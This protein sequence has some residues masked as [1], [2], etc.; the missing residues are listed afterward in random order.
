MSMRKHL[1]TTITETDLEQFDLW[2]RENR[3]SRGDGIGAL[4]R[5]VRSLSRSTVDIQPSVVVSN[6]TESVPERVVE[7]DE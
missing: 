5:L 2:C 6:W 1:H 7:L 4:V 3:L